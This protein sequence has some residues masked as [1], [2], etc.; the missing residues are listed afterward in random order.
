[1]SGMFSWNRRAEAGRF[2]RAPLCYVDG[3]TCQF[4]RLVV[5]DTEDSWGLQGRLGEAGAQHLWTP[6]WGLDRPMEPAVR[7]SRKQALRPA[8]QGAKQTFSQSMD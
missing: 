5:L 3:L 1:M 8:G 6:L 2:E 4:P 7:S